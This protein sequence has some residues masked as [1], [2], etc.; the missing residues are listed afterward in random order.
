VV[1]ADSLRR[2]GRICALPS[3]RMI[4]FLV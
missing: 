3:G 4:S 2:G 1:K